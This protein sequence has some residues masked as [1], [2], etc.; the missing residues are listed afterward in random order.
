M[1]LASRG[2]VRPGLLGAMLVAAVVLAVA[3]LFWSAS[4]T[5]PTAAP[6]V[7]PRAGAQVVGRVELAA[8]APSPPARATLAVYAYALDGPRLPLAL[9]KLPAAGAALPLDFKLDDTLA[10]NP[11]YRLSQAV[12]V[13]VGARLSIGGG[14]GDG[15]QPGDWL[16]QPQTVALGTHGVRLVLQ[17]PSR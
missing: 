16:A 8:G 12:Q 5:T 9:L 13:V 7:A 15:A 17:P 10:P 1:S 2:A 11:A 4:R 14:D 6:A 3:A